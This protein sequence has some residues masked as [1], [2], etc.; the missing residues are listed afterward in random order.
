MTDDFV[1]RLG[2]ALRDA[3]DREERRR[4]PW[5][6]AAIA[7]ARIPRL[8]TSP[9]LAT[10]IAGLV[11]AAAVYGL[12]RLHGSAPA[13]APAGPRVVARLTPAGGLDAI[14]PAFGSAW[15]IDTDSKSLL[16]MDAA[17]RRV[18][19]RFPLGGTMSIAAG[20]A[21][22]WVGLTEND[23]FHLLRIDPSTNRIVAR[24]RPPGVPGRSA[25]ANPVMI[26]A[27]LWLLGA[28]G[29]ERLDPANGHAIAKVRIARNGYT[30]RSFA[31]TGGDLWVHTSDGR[32]QRLDGTTG[33]REA[34]FRVP[35]G[36]VVGDFG[37]NALFI[38]DVT[39]LSRVDPRN[40]HVLWRTTIPSIGTGVAAGGRLWVETPDTH[41]DRVLTVDPGTGH[42]IDSVHVG[43]FGAQWM[44]PVGAHEVWMTTAGGHVIILGR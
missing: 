43:E 9:V 36:S 15:M 11:L 24:L 31:V 16:R 27:K 34:S 37:M 17:T 14:V 6:A 29:A 7:R 32:L 5:R 12:A 21:A 33:R 8:Q 40:L 1:T 28:E 13:P 20:N 3:A 25:F 4:T 19:A 42:V 30:T 39:T 10:L 41:G 38:G 26:G 2:V 23:D 18:T 35:D 44:A 22:I